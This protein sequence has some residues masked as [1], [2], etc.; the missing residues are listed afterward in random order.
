MDISSDSNITFNFY[1]SAEISEAKSV[2]LLNLDDFVD[3]PM[4][5]VINDQNNEMHDM[6]HEAYSIHLGD[7]DSDY[8]MNHSYENDFL[9]RILSNIGY[10]RIEL[11]REQV[12]QMA[13]AFSDNEAEKLKNM[14]KPP[15]IQRKKIE[16][17]NDISPE[18][19][20][21]KRNSDKYKNKWIALSSDN[22]IAVGNNRKKLFEKIKKKNINSDILI[23]Y[24]Y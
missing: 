9:N 21:I 19:N 17:K 23:H 1:N 24:I 3:T 6:C 14:I 5:Q 20:W 13:N 12:S 15:V 16:H 4:E 11:A 8:S 18:V 7:G 2:A 10:G 22:L